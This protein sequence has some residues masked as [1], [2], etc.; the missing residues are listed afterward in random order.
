M[1]ECYPEGTQTPCANGALAGVFLY[2]TEVNCEDGEQIK[3]QIIT[4]AFTCDDMDYVPTEYCLDWGDG[5]YSSGVFPT[6]YA[7]VRNVEL[8]HVYRY[9]NVAKYQSSTYSPVVTI[10]T[11]CG[12]IRSVGNAA[13]IYCFRSGVAVPVPNMRTYKLHPDFNNASCIGNLPDCTNGQSRC[14]NGRN[15]TCVSGTWQLNTNNPQCGSTA[16]VCDNTNTKCV[17]GRKLSWCIL[18]GVGG[19]TDNG[20]GSCTTGDDDYDTCTRPCSKDYCDGSGVFYKC[21]GGC[22]VVS[23]TTCVP[24]DNEDDTSKSDDILTSIKNFY[25]N[26]KTL[27]ILGL[28][29]LGGFMVFGGKRN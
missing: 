7:V 19:Y 13:H 28:A 20:L 9:G 27:T 15:E 16:R 5:T 21:Y 12:G 25:N 4:N 23:G 22:A 6:G 18:D 11:A 2:P 24:D 3:L 14:N 17:N 8:S 10:K 29:C 1:V 26:N